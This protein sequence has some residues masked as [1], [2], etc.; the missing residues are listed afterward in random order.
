MNTSRPK[1]GIALSGAS[2]RAIAHIAVL[3]VLQENAEEVEKA[4]K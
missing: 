1:I 3:E 2:G 4:L